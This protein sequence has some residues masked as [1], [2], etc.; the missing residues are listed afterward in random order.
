MLQ[1]VYQRYVDQVHGGWIGKSMG[2][3]IGARFEGTKEWLNLKPEEMFP[4]VIPP[5]DDLDMSVLWL[6]ILEEK[7]IKLTAEDLGKAW[8]ELCWYP[9]NEFGIFRRNWRLGIPPPMS[10]Q[11]TNQFWETGMGC[12]MRAE[13][14]GYVFP[15]APDLAADFAR[16][17]G[18]LDHGIQSTGGEMMLAAM[19]SMA[20]F[21]PDVRR[22]IAQS[23][24]FLP[25]NTPIKR[26]SIAAINAFDEG[27]SLQDARQRVIALEGNPETSDA[28]TNLPFI[29]LAL[30]YGGNDLEKTILAAISCGYDTDTTGASAGALIGQILGASHIAPPL[31]E[32]IGDELVMGIKYRRDEMT[33]SALAR[34]TARMGARLAVDGHTGVEFAGFGGNLGE[35][36]AVSPSPHLVVS[37]EGLP[38]AAPGDNKVVIL[39]LKDEKFTRGTIRVEGP[40][41]WSVQP[42]EIKIDRL[43]R[44]ARFNINAPLKTDK[45]QMENRFLA[46]FTPSGDKDLITRSFGVMGAGLWEFLGVYFDTLPENGVVVHPDKIFRQHFVSLNRNYLP[47]PNPDVKSIYQAWSRKLGRE[48]VVPSYENEIDLTRL[49]GLQGA[50]CAYLARTVF[51]P[52]HRLAYLVIGNTDSYRLY[53][54]NERVAEVDEC[55]AWSPFNNVHKV[56]LQAGPNQLL[57]K[58][59]KRTDYLRFTIAIRE[60]AENDQGQNTMDWMIDL[61]DELPPD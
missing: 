60:R 7:G 48:A 34:D 2:G 57:L 22:L 9:F 41:G 13:I 14:W 29:L 39:S 54:N 46:K 30:L 3:T 26:L 24:H 61:A 4:P 53:L 19:C 35:V 28:Q 51:C 56:E 18:S 12:P 43:H 49:I 47:E 50:Y 11:F 20:F 38:C 37:Y 45:W 59:L 31:K 33:L 15:G 5:N 25:E 44:S 6:K 27:V 42:S 23:I 10:G 21:N 40:Q 32:K 16:L 58:L 55:V 52:D 36:K 1:L 17:D 8:L